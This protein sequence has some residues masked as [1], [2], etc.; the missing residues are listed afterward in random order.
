MERVPMTR[1]ESKDAPVTMKTD[2]ELRP[3]QPQA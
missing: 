2:P 1:Q 3:N